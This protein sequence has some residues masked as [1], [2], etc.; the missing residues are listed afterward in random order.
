MVIGADNFGFPSAISHLFTFTALC[1][2]LGRTFCVSEVFSE[3]TI[4]QL[5]SPWSA[6]RPARTRLATP[7]RTCLELRRYN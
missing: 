3:T 4:P 7:S 5:G 2:E 6:F 1:Q